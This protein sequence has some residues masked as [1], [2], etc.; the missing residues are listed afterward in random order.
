MSK[1]NKLKSFLVEGNR[2]TPNQISA[3][4][5]IANPSAA[6]HQLRKQ[7]V[8]IYANPKTL[9]SGERTVEYK[10]G[11]PLARVLAAAYEAGI[12]G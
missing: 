3:R 6:I 1:V 7:G 5:K 12:R 9:S 8:F 10:V 11:K 2:A 4:F